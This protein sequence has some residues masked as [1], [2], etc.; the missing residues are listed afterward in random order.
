MDRNYNGSNK[1]H[2]DEPDDATT[3]SSKD[4]LKFQKKLAAL[5][6]L[7]LKEQNFYEKECQEF[8]P[9]KQKP[10]LCQCG[11]AFTE[12]PT[13]VRDKPPGRDWDSRDSTK[14]TP[15]RCFGTIRFK[16]QDTMN[17]NSPYMRINDDVNVS[18]LVEYV[19]E[20]WQLSKPSLI[21][22]VTGGAADFA[23]KKKDHERL[24]QGL[25]RVAATKG[26]WFITGGSNAGI[27]K[28]CGEASRDQLLTSNS[29]S[30]NSR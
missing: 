27:M 10:D 23:M 3:R 29:S 17:S 7:R 20:K 6:S 9:K 15:W 28:I 11:S 2:P 22:S 16:N 5:A 18:Q 4:G 24:K 26:A 12:H 25:Q 30:S 19:H 13:D 8:C 14:K 1:I 21:I